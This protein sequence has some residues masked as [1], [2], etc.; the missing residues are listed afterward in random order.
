MAKYSVILTLH[1]T[2]GNEIAVG[3]VRPIA[4]ELNWTKA[5]TS[6]GVDSI[7]FKVNDKLLDKWARERGY[8]IN[9]LL[10]PYAL[11]AVVLREGEPLVGGFLATMPAYQPL[12][13]SAALSMR[14]DGWMNLLAGCY[15]RPRVRQSKPAG[16]MVADWIDEADTRSHNAGKAFNFHRG[17]ISSLATVERTFDSYKTIKEAITQLCDNV[18]G[19]GPFDVIFAPDRTYT[20][21]NA[22][23]REIEDWALHY[24]ASFEGTGVASISA[25]EVQGFASHVI[26]LG[27]GETSADPVKSTVVT[28]EATDRYGVKEYGYVEMLTQYSSISR[29]STLDNR[30]ATDL[31]YASYIQWQPDV[32]LF[33]IQTP[34]SPTAEH[35]LWIGD[36]ID[37]INTADLTGQTSGR[38]KV[39]QIEVTVG[40]TGAESVKP[41]LERIA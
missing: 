6:T 20:I 16:I 7:N 17:Y 5:R 15:L 4:E 2:E 19:A 3:D 27:S 11:E 35:G 25:P 33:G 39:N 21:T 23:G 28:S 29:Q 37:L 38:F 31:A 26:T 40:A 8:T 9:D 36:R 34:P 18:D 22:L 10:R 41:T 14:F 30:C 13:A 1:E 24:P 32:T 12:N